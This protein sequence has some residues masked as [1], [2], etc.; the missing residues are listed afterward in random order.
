M[1]YVIY[2]F[3]VNPGLEMDFEQDWAALTHAFITHSNGMGSRL[4]K[5]PDGTYIAYAEWPNKETWET[6]GDHLPANAKKLSERMRSTLTGFEI[7]H[8]L[9]AVKDLLKPGTNNL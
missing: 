9:D 6:A 1:F 7:L 4:H 5:T 2:K 3:E 8:T